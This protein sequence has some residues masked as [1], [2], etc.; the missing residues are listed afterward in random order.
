[1]PTPIIE[2]KQVKKSFRD[3]HAVR[4]IDLELF[5]GEFIAVLGPNG[6]GK[7]TLVEMIEGIQKPDSGSIMLKGKHWK[8]NESSLNRILGISLQET[9]FI[10]KLTVFETLRLFA[11]FY[12]LD[13]KRVL[14][15]ISLIQLEDKT[16]AYIK[17]LSG[18]QRQRLALGISLLNYPEVLLLDEPTTGLDPNARH[19]IWNI[20]L[21]LKEERNTSM[22]LTTHYMEEAEFLCDRIII[23]DNGKILAKGTL[24]DLLTHCETHE[25]IEFSI[26]G[27]P[28][29]DF[30]SLPGVIKVNLNKKDTVFTLEVSKIIETLPAMLKKLD[31]S[32]TEIKN[33]QCRKLTLDDLFT[34]LTGRHLNA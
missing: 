31:E 24:E 8:G 10:E 19:D 30:A 14:E 29:M 3:V 32:N 20:L 21:K 13:K 28:P 33:L 11:S 2:V 25:I 7:T 4:G 12:K 23:I 16:K 26:T 5:P 27:V 6:A 17:N 18:G 34:S 22:I 15:I 9:W 1:M